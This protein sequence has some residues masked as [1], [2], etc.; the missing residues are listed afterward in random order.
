[1]IKPNF[2]T[3]GSII[4]IQPQRPIISFVFNDSISKI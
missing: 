1:M 3:L 2:S 4:E